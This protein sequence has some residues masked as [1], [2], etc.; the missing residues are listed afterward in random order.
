MPYRVAYLVSH[1]IQYQAPLL[2]YLAVQPDLDLTVFFLSD[3]SIRE[4]RDPGFGIGV[5]WDVPLLGGYRHEFLLPIRHQGRL[6]AWRPW[7]LRFREQLKVERFDVL[8]VHGYGHPAMVLAIVTARRFG[9]PVLLR[10][11]S[12]LSSSAA[13]F[14]GKLGKQAVLPLLFRLVDGFLVI[15]TMNRSFYQHYGVPDHQLFWMPYAVDND[16]FSRRAAESQ[17]TRDL[18]RREL[19]LEPGRSI[20]L[21]ASKL[22]SWKRPADL[23]EAFRRLCS[24]GGNRSRPY[25]LIIGDG[26]ERQQLEAQASRLGCGA[27]KFLGFRNQTE[28]PRFYDLADVF[29]LPS[30]SEPWGLVVNEA[31]N[32]SKAVIV[33]D[34]VGAGPDL[35]RDGSNG[36]VVP[37]GDIE[38]LANR[39]DLLASSPDLCRM[40]GCESA[41]RIREWDFAT[42][43]E[44]LRSA[45]D[46][47]VGQ[48]R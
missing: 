7:L 24:L 8:W 44:G 34:R 16:F 37:V 35:V 48:R 23:L 39:L 12:H 33:S 9:I 26:P 32:A 11:E 22:V 41:K 45:L 31:M 14:I 6:R 28:L 27:V 25:L 43:V 3:F 17:Q 18:L 20:I 1:P 29:V 38:T 10:G 2:R 15:G 13:G 47:V 21:F 36:F 42:D 40:M 30:A 5:R 46:V 19:G 4:Y